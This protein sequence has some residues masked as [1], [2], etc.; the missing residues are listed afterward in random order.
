MAVKRDPCTI[1]LLFYPYLFSTIQNKKE[2]YNTHNIVKYFAWSTDFITIAICYLLYSDLVFL[3]LPVTIIAGKLPVS[4]RYL[5][6]KL[7]MDR[8][9]IDDYDNWHRLIWPTLYI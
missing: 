8:V 1:H 9:E 5:T 7:S 3:K 2:P 4:Y 6:G